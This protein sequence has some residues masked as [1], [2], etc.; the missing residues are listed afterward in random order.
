MISIKHHA[1]YESVMVD[2]LDEVRDDLKDEQV[3]YIIKKYSSFVFTLMAAVIIGVALKLWWLSYNENKSYKE[4]GD[5]VT[6]LMKVQSRNTADGIKLFQ[7]LATSGSTNYA[8]LAD[9]HVA[10]YNLHNNEIDKALTEYSALSNNSG[11]ADV[12]RQYSS[13]MQIKGELN[14]P[15]AD[16][17]KLRDQLDTYLQRDGVFKYTAMELMAMLY[18]D[19]G[20]G[21][22]ARA[23][24][25]AIKDAPEAPE[26]MKDRAGQILQ[27]I[28]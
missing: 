11:Y 28:K 5:F 8:A 22:K 7:Q 25:L 6:A 24:L 3:F 13:L 20:E 15:N 4:G 10:A 26:N 1:K 27:T 23:E 9:L 2:L 14:K 12:L 18:I 16:K 17:V 19:M 21:V